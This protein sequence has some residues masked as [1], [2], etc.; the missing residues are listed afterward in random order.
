MLGGETFKVNEDLNVIEEEE[1]GVAAADGASTTSSRAGTE[2][3]DISILDDFK[4]HHKFGK[5][6]S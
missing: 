6:H 2:G 3:G 1:E 5:K 4:P